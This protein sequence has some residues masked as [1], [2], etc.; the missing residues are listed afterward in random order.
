[1]CSTV[2]RKGGNNG[3]AACIAGAFLVVVPVTCYPPDHCGRVGFGR[4]LLD[5][6]LLPHTFV[7]LPFSFS[8]LS[9]FQGRL[10]AVF[11]VIL[12]LCPLRE[13]DYAFA[14]PAWAANLV[15]NQREQYLDARARDSAGASCQLQ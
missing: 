2:K 7:S 6:P 3:A 1:M 9:A 4:P 5:L 11:I 15:R 10:L 8:C 13:A 14:A 12:P